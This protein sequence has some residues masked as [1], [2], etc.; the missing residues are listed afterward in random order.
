M[1]RKLSS[2]PFPVFK[3]RHLATNPKKKEKTFPS[4]K[5]HCCHLQPVASTW[6]W[7]HR[8]NE[9]LLFKQLRFIWWQFF[10]RWGTTIYNISN[11]TR[12]QMIIKVSNNKKV[13]KLKKM[14]VVIVIF[15]CLLVKTKFVPK[16]S[17][18]LEFR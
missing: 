16:F 5:L 2:A 10:S 12:Y 17:A 15:F 14:N 1:M 3:R 8:I 7:W 6:I 9:W 11:M 13:L 4:W 18:I